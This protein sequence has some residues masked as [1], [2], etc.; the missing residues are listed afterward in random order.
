MPPI[1]DFEGGYYAMPHNPDHASER[2]ALIDRANQGQ[3][4]RVIGYLGGSACEL[5]V[6]PGKQPI[7]AGGR[8]TLSTGR[9]YYGE[10]VQ[11]AR[12]AADDKA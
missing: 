1:P 8:M 11:W 9:A 12:V 10:D 5:Y 4:T 2:I 3:V 6:E 7:E